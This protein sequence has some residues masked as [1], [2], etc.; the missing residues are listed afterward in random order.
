MPDYFFVY[1]SYLTKRT[2]RRLGRR[3]SQAS[4]LPDAAVEDMVRAAT[5]LGFHVTAE[6]G[7]QYPR[8]SYRLAGRLKVSKKD[9]VTKGEFLRRLAEELRRHPP[10]GAEER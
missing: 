5:T 6:P 3:L 8:E 9:G 1:P 10:A 7:K 4:A 2:S